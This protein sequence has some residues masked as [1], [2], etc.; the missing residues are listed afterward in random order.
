MGSADPWPDLTGKSW[1]HKTSTQMTDDEVNDARAT[2]E[3]VGRNDYE[4]EWLRRHGLPEDF[5][6]PA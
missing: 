3:A 5:G 4:S 2:F 1:A 6:D